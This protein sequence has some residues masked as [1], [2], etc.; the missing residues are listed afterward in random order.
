M[1]AYQILDLVS[2][3][4]SRH[5]E[6]RH[7]AIRELLHFARTDLREMSQDA[8][9]Q[10]LDDFNQ[11]I[12]ALTSSYDN[13]EKKAGIL[14]IGNVEVIAPPNHKLNNNLI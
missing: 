3:L 2:G 12:H 13:N 11:H 1:T 4:K 5:A 9:T 6:T 7:K 10:V 8:L 14:T